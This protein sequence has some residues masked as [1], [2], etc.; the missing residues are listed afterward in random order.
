M[1]GWNEWAVFSVW[2][3]AA[4]KSTVVLSA[5]WVAAFVLRRRSAAARH[6]VWTAA[7]AAVLA[8][9][10]LSI[11]MPAWRVPASHT[12]LAE[13]TG[14]VFQ[15]FSAP[16]S[17]APAAS[18]PAV[19]G[20]AAPAK[21]A[22]VR[23]GAR[24]WLMLLWA[25]GTALAALQMV[26]AWAGVRRMRRGARRFADARLVG[27]L[28]ESLGIRQ[29][30]EVLESP[31]NR[32]PMTYGLRRPTVFLPEGAAEW[33]A[34]RLQVVLLHELAHVRRGDAATQLMARAALCLHWWNPLARLGWREF[35]KERERAAD[36]LVLNAGAQASQYASLLLEVA[37]SLDSASPALVGAAMA[38]RSQLE[39]RLLAILD[40]G[41]NRGAV[42][43]AAPVVATIAAVALMAPFAAVQAQDGQ[44]MSAGLDA[45]IRA[46]NAQKNHE[47]LERAASAY[48]TLR[49]YDVAQTLLESAA[50]IRAEVS[51]PQSAAYAAGLVKLGDLAAKRRQHAEALAFYNK[52]VALGDR[53]E[54]VP[55]LLYL[56]Q[57]TRPQ[58]AAAQFFQRAL[59]ADPDGPQ[60][61]LATAWLAVMRESDPI[62]AESL[63]QT[64]LTK[65]KP[66]SA[67]MATALGL[68]SHFLKKQGRDAEADEVDARF[69]EATQAHIA[70]MNR[71]LAEA[72]SEELK[73]QGGTAPQSQ[74]QAGGG[75]APA[76]A[77]GA[78]M[79]Q[80]Q[81]RPGVYRVGGGVTAPSLL[82]KIEPE[83]TEAARAARYQGTVLI[84]V[85]VGPDGYAHNMKVM[86]GLGLGLDER[87]IDAI[88]QWKFKPGIKDGQPVTVA[89][90]I[91]VNFRLQ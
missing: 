9:P 25:A 85:E 6:L 22:R 75:G 18:L 17:D 53:P 32:M 79:P 71:Q 50:A 35:L 51:G 24:F 60:A 40:S 52:A 23:P 77:P 34:E 14:L 19:G 42:R 63:Y 65:A 8:L 37:Q 89:A 86:R 76:V 80:P 43:R 39:G 69:K 46:A 49:Q 59:N 81:T 38:R 31:A 68:Y 73:F 3:G 54:V 55:A 16:A 1:P 72:R 74:A 48:E 4:L 47:I 78:P 88:S 62:E 36:D 41:A 66:D 82:S 12:L 27:C 91:E 2:M 21:M 56:G 26:V 13:G 11:S 61:G 84:F 90:T 20:A 44:A 67:E 28:A 57:N 64:A 33:S 30:V 70:N 87:A 15:V 7:A 58:S 5:A 29:D 10:W 45:T 83:Y